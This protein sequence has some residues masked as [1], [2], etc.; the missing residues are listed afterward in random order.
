M[1]RLQQRALSVLLFVL[2][3][4]F[5]EKASASVTQIVATVYFT[6]VVNGVTNG[7]TIT[8]NGSIRRYT[9]GVLNSAST[10]I[11]STNRV[12]WAATNTLSH[13][14]QYLATGTEYVGAT[15][16]NAVIIAGSV[17]NITHTVTLSA[18]IG[19]NT[20]VT[21]V[22]GDYLG[23]GGP[24]ASLPTAAGRT[25]IGSKLIDAL[26]NG[27]TTNLVPTVE[28]G[29][30]G[31]S[32]YVDR[33]SQQ[34]VTNKV[35][36][37]TT[38]YGGLSDG[39]R[40]TNVV[41]LSGSNG[42]L[43][44]IN[45]QRGSLL[46]VTNISGTNANFTN[47]LLRHVSFID[48]NPR[49]T[50]VG[51]TNGVTVNV[52]N[53]NSVSSNHVNYGNAIRSEGTGGNSFQVGSNA[54]AR[55]DFSI[56]VG[57]DSV[58]SNSYST[59][60]GRA[61]VSTNNYSTALGDSAKA[62]AIGSTSIGQNSL[63]S[64]ASSLA[65]GNA[66]NATGTKSIAVG[67]VISSGA[68]AIGIGPDDETYA[69]GDFSIAIGQSAKAITNSSV[70]IGHSA[71]AP[72][73]NSA[74]LG[75]RDHLGNQTATTTTNQVRLGTALMTVSIP[76]QLQAESQTNGNF[77]GTNIWRGDVSYLRY[78][79]ATVA[80]GHNTINVG[81]NVVI[82]LTGSPSAAW[83][84]G[85]ISGGN[86]DGKL[87]KVRN[88]TG[89]TVD[90]IHNSGTEPTASQRISTPTATN[91]VLYTAGW[92]EFW[93]DTSASRWALL[94]VFN[95]ATPTASATNAIA[96]LDGSG[97]N[98]NVFA[99]ATG[100]AMVIRPSVGGTADIFLIK[101]TNNN[102]LMKLTSNG[103]FVL[104]PTP[105]ST[106]NTFSIRHTNAE[107]GLFH[108]VI[109]TGGFR[110]RTGA[111]ADTFDVQNTNAANVLGVTSNNIVYA[112]AITG[113]TNNI[114]E[115]RT[116][117]GA[118]AGLMRSNHTMVVSNLNMTPASLVGSS[119]G[120][121][122][123]AA[124]RLFSLT[125]TVTITNT[126]AATSWL[127]N[128][129]WGSQVIGANELKPGMTIRI[130]GSG[131]MTSASAVPTL[132]GLRMNNGTDLATNYIAFA[133]ALVNDY[134][135]FEISFSVR[136]TGA[137]GTVMAVGGLMYQATTGSP[138]SAITRRLQRSVGAGPP[139]TATIDTTVAQVI[140]FYIT[141]GAATH[142]FSLVQ[143]TAE[144]IP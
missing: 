94:N 132:I 33:S 18:G 143:C 107:V 141:P 9:N 138:N 125:N 84:W 63:A 29:A 34:V 8:I 87:I 144:I 113:T 26:G 7:D 48:A 14:A 16:T 13:L 130:R 66:A 99:S 38:N 137:S 97:T 23:F 134:I 45:L 76:G 103:V 104:Q 93:Y 64:G 75:P 78:S 74:A 81:T 122:V 17:G 124:Y 108:N 36:Y 62:Y 136:S 127:T 5:A 30:R 50:N 115:W 105:L 4:C 85:G 21:N 20:Y 1:I 88:N 112:S 59:A 49:G 121:E 128:A 118:V 79:V 129:L 70:A 27:Y 53:I 101:H 77:T 131:Y 24:L 91:V 116:T 123:G 15:N 57:N 44:D 119:G 46:N 52:T 72:F 55:G 65:V 142:G 135:Q 56:A 25:N 28:G 39:R 92:A 126:V 47:V 6:N 114:M 109:G 110:A 71:S 82:D 22:Y 11:Q 31:F 19:T 98:L 10:W 106:T 73:P 32:N 96:F 95:T 90:I 43:A 102:E 51:F 140:D 61:A 120:N 100:T 89:Y 67:G 3:A 60:I 139:T 37:A 80:N 83:T 2:L 133:T 42:T 69:F 41:S 40:I 54:Q 12:G 86:R 35:L 117:N 68:S 58:A 111:T